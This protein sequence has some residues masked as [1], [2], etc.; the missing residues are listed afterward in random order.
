MEWSGR[1]YSHEMKEIK[2][3]CWEMLWMEMC[4]TVEKWV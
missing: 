3:C 1:L 2:E 4:V